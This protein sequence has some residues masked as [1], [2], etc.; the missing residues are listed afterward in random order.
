MRG[1]VLLEALD[2][3][4]ATAG[5]APRGPL[6]QQRAGVIRTMVELQ[7][8]LLEARLHDAERRDLLRRLEGLEAEEAE[9]RERLAREDPRFAALRAPSIPSL[10]ELRRALAEDEAMLSYAVA[11]QDWLPGTYRSRSWLLVATR[12][13]V[14]V[15]PLPELASSGSR[16]E[17]FLGLIA[18]RDGAEERAAV[19]L[20]EDLFGRA[21]E[22]LPARIRHLIVLPDGAL[23]R[24]PFA[25]LRATPGKAP[26]GARY[27]I[28]VAPSATLW[29]RWRSRRP[30]PSAVSVLAL[31]DPDLPVHARGAPGD[32]AWVLA[33]G[34]PLTQLPH[35]R[36]EARFVA[37]LLRGERRLGSEATESFV[38][39][40]PLGRFGVLHLAAHALVD[41]EQ[42]ERS[43]IVLAPGGRDEDGLLQFREI[44]ALPL[45]DRVVVLAA[46]QSASG[47][48]VAGEGVMGLARAFFQAGA[49]TVVGSLWPQRD[50]EAERLMRELYGHLAEGESVAAALSA[51]QRDRLSAGAPVAAWAGLVVL[52]DG[53]VAPVPARQT[54]SPG[55]TGALLRGALLVLVSVLLLRMLLSRRRARTSP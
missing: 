28:S 50:D 37:D 32:R 53:D 9:L 48:V 14:D 1:R 21:L 40:T 8:R 2:W 25:A 6:Q 31:A 13:G 15:T 47:A 27:R 4:Q 26:L 49:R 30:Q 51:A 35:A 43:A 46:C 11:T 38:K 45:A 12:Q 42:P 39:T 29:L 55:A 10:A 19:R 7:R 44:V 17:L 20:H 41:D 18:R 34:A 5:I 23:N 54:P 22:R 3:A 24:L 16:V 52:G 33:T 36:A